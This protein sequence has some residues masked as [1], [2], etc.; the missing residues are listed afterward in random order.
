MRVARRQRLPLEPLLR[1]YT[2]A[3]IPSVDDL[4]RQPGIGARFRAVLAARV[5]FLNEPFLYNA[6]DSEWRTLLGRFF[7]EWVR[8]PLHAA[9]LTQ[10]AS[11]VRHALG[12]LLRGGDSLA[13]RVERCLHPDGPY[14][15]AGLG[16]SFWSAILQGLQ[17]QQQVAWTP[18]NIR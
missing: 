7:R 3:G 9:T 13:Q 17:P 14:F 1:A 12:H 11:L 16:Q 8:P 2:S 4:I 18:T 10:R 6:S 5:E 15:V